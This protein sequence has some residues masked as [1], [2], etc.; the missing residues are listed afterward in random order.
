MEVLEKLGGMISQNNMDQSVALFGFGAKV[1][2]HRQPSHCFP[3][4]D[5]GNVKGIKVTE[6]KL[7]YW[8]KTH[9]GNDHYIVK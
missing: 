4:T 1:A 7:I 8:L 2:N 5:D 9:G 3:L 6:N